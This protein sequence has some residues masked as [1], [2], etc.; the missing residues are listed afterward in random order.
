MEVAIY[1]NRWYMYVQDNLNNAKQILSVM[2][3]SNTSN[4]ETDRIP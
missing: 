3:G 4:V 2:Y 1:V